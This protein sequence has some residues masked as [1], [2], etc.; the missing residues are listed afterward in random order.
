VICESKWSNN[1]STSFFTRSFPGGMCCDRI[2]FLLLEEVIMKG[3]LSLK[4]VT[5]G[6]GA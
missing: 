2:L 6:C 5:A 1:E 4:E 3:T